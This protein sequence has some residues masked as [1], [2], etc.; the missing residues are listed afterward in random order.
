ML[1][2]NDEANE[3]N[4]YQ[5]EDMKDGTIYNWY[6]MAWLCTIRDINLGVLSRDLCP[7]STQDG[8]RRSVRTHTTDL[9]RKIVNSE[10]QLVYA[11]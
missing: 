4:V 1:T 7:Q 10:E 3:I 8:T 11:K 5:V 6:D 2:G 9:P